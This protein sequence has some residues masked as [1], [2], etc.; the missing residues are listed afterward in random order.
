MGQNVCSQWYLLKKVPLYVRREILACV[1]HVDNDVLCMYMF[2]IVS[3]L[4]CYQLLIV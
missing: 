2:N 1:S 3:S 4:F